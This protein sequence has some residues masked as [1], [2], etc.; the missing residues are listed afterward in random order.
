MA[1]FIDLNLHRPAN[2]D[3]PNKPPSRYIE[4]HAVNEEW[5]AAKGIAGAVWFTKV[6][7]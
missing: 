5:L 7:Q 1:K 6:A 3:N 4:T 2:A